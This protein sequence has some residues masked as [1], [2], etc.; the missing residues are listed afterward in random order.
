MLSKRGK[1]ILIRVATVVAGLAVAGSLQMPESRYPLMELIVSLQRG[2]GLAIF[3]LMTMAV[4]L[5][6]AYAVEWYR[7]DSGIAIG[8][9]LDYSFQTLWPKVNA[10]LSGTNEQNVYLTTVLA[11]DALAVMVWLY[12]FVRASRMEDFVTVP[13]LRKKFQ[14]IIGGK[15]K[16]KNHCP[17]AS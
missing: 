5:A 1:R 10:F 12:S 9:F 15:H 17:L 14:L 2:V 4:V 16:P 11:L 3:S 13:L 8:L 7:R 6:Q